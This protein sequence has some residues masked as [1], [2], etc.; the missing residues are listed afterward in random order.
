MAQERLIWET[1]RQTRLGYASLTI[2]TTPEEA[3][4]VL[5]FITALTTQPAA[6]Y[7]WL[8]HN[9]TT[10]CQDA[11]H[12]LGLDLHDISPRAFW[13]AVYRRYSMNALKHPIM[14]SVQGHLGLP[15][16][17]QPG[18]DY[19]NPRDYGMNFDDLLF[20]LYQNQQQPQPPVTVCTDDGLGNR[21][22]TTE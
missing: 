2:Q 3:Q 21:Q 12:D 15:V 19:G 8:S 4:K 17:D 18:V 20:Q 22:C 1:Q 11:L 10:V 6:D 16:P 9:C 7:H 14:N 5:D 13:R